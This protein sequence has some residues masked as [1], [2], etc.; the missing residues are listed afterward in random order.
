M[1]VVY[2]GRYVCMYVC[3]YGCM[4]VCMYLC[5]YVC[6]WEGANNFFNGMVEKTLILRWVVCYAL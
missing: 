5:M 1:Y 4:Y 2:V 3:M 6:M